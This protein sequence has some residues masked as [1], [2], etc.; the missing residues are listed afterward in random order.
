MSHSGQLNAMHEISLIRYINV[1]DWARIIDLCV[2]ASG[3][4]PT[5]V[6]RALGY[7]ANCT[8]ND[9]SNPSGSA[10]S[11]SED[12]RRLLEKMQRS[13][14]ACHPAYAVSLIKTSDV[15]VGPLKGYIGDAYSDVI[16]SS[17]DTSNRI[18][19]DLKEIDEMNTYMRDVTT[20]KTAL[21]IRSTKCDLCTQQLE[22]PST[23][24]WC[25][26]SYH[27]YCLGGDVK[28]AKCSPDAEAKMIS[29][30][31]RASS[32]TARDLST[33]DADVFLKH[34]SASSDPLGYA[35]SYFGLGIFNMDERE[36][37]IVMG[38]AI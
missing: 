4:D 6:N 26:H 31:Q 33:T 32:D 34:L 37:E 18:E 22:M 19:K 2:T 28:C 9:T 5:I 11:T 29:L 21:E 1:N 8:N 35:M 16:E 7:V 13:D 17:T 36:L 14:I 27:S 20:R 38:E 25:K 10:P 23:H 3:H 24:F 12:V 30:Q 15:A